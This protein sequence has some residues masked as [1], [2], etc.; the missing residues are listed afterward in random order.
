VVYDCKKVKAGSDTGIESVMII[1][2]FFSVTVIT[3]G[4]EIGVFEPI[5]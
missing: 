5:E 2:S 4:N 1:Q 3:L